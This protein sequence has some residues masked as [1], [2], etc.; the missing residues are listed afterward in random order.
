[1]LPP[2][3]KQIKILN[4][5]EGDHFY[6]L[7]K[8]CSFLSQISNFNSSIV[9]DSN[10]IQQTCNI[11][12]QWDQGG[13]KLSDTLGYFQEPLI[14]SSMSAL[15]IFFHAFTTT[16][17]FIHIS[18]HYYNQDGNKYAK[19]EPRSVSTLDHNRKCRLVSC[20]MISWLTCCLVQKVLSQHLFF[21]EVRLTKN[22]NF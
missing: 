16:S 3:G 15:H 10:H 7:I 5:Y 20:D 2:T 22:A 1:M 6:F 12:H 9:K 18:S 11:Q 17:T 21:D 13:A 14:S 8:M 4:W 19:Y